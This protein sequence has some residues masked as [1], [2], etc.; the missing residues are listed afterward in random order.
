M[1]NDEVGSDND[2]D[3]D[4]SADTGLRAITPFA[5]LRAAMEPLPNV[6][7]YKKV[8]KAGTGELLGPRPANV[9]WTYD[10]YTENEQRPYDTSRKGGVQAAIT[11]A[12][13]AVHTGVWMSL[14]TMCKGEEAEFVI[15]YRLMFGTLGL[16]PR[17]KQKADIL[18]AVKLVDFTEVGGASDGGAQSRADRRKFANV[19][20][21]ATDMHAKALSFGRCERYRN[22]TRT[23]L[24]AVQMLELSHLAGEA[25]QREQRQMLIRFYGD[26]ME[27]YAK[28]NEHRKVCTM[29][30][31]LRRLK[32][33]K[34]DVNV[35]LHEAIAVSNIENTAHRAL[36]I[37]EQCERIEPANGLVAGV[38]VTILAKQK[39]YEEDTKSL[40]Q[41]AFRL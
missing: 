30:N 6:H 24:S 3:G 8:V 26:L 39:K 36:Q 2:D 31:E 22:A 19:K 14:E 16:V 37:L 12:Y 10:A 41:R 25:E 29:I 18:L 33:I 15:D 7:I 4:D 35:L 40:W 32:C 9:Q 5:E 13:H 28:A 20:P 38:K 17:I 34:R 21:K 11:T 23:L 27:L 1:L